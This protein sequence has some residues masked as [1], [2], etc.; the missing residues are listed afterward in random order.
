MKRSF[1]FVGAK[2]AR[3][4]VRRCAASARRQE[5]ERVRAALH[6]GGSAGD[7]RAYRLRVSGGRATRSAT[8]PADTPCLNVCP[9]T[10]TPDE[11]AFTVRAET[12]VVARRVEIPPVEVLGV[13]GE[14]AAVARGGAPTQLVQLRAEALDEPHL[15]AV[16]RPRRRVR[17]PQPTALARPAERVPDDAR[18]PQ[19][20]RPQPQAAAGRSSRAAG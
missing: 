13:A 3:S 9:T 20:P 7:E 6:L 19:R 10:A 16:D 2:P 15:E 8:N 11:L 14:V 4:N 12:A 18:G 1:L 5:H 17:R